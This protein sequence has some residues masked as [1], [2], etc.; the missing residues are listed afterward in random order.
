VQLLPPTAITGDTWSLAL[1]LATVRADA[2]LIIASVGELGSDG[3]NT[4]AITLQEAEDGETI[5]SAAAYSAVAAA[6]IDGTELAATV[7]VA[8]ESSTYVAGYK[9]TARYLA[10]KF[11]E[12][13]TISG[14]VSAH[15]VLMHLHE[16]PGA[17]FTVTTGQPA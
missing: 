14:P 5:T 1:D 7:A 2:V 11:D 17:N 4:L 15:A 9:G 10:V 13:N 6:D 8:G 16:A 12:T 3:S